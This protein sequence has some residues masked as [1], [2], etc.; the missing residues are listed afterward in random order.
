VLWSCHG[1]TIRRDCAPLLP[2]G[3][4]MSLSKRPRRGDIYFVHADVANDA[5]P[6]AYSA[7]RYNCDSAVLSRDG[8]IFARTAGAL[9]LNL[10]HVL[11]H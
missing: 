11:L 1:A 5:P 10:P 2:G 9:T 7:N 4:S 3:Q 8:V 6:F